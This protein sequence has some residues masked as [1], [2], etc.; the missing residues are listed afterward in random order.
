MIWWSTVQTRWFWAKIIGYLLWI[1]KQRKIKEREKFL[2]K[3]WTTGDKEGI[4]GRYLQ[5]TS[6]SNNLFFRYD[7]LPRK[8]DGD[9]A[10]TPTPLGVLC[11][12][13]SLWYLLS[14]PEALEVACSFF[15]ACCTSSCETW[16]E[17]PAPF[18]R[19]SSFWIA[20][21]S[22]WISTGS[23]ES[24]GYVQKSIWNWELVSS[25]LFL[26]FNRDWKFH[27][28]YYCQ[29]IKFFRKRIEERQFYCQVWLNP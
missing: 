18:K 2:P 16:K 1:L 21:G 6:G 26:F 7:E 17:I 19:P 27:N 3:G 4:V 13:L 20:I 11:T 12:S 9:L 14:N 25:K 28:C 8:F 23:R 5:T 15:M 29:S 10:P 22:T 24:V